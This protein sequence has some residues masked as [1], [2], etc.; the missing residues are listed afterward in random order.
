MFL[1]GLH[2]FRVTELIYVLMLIYQVSAM[3]SRVCLYEKQ[4]SSV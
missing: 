4:A 3:Y 1:L 2:W